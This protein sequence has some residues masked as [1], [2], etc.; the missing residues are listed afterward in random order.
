[1]PESGLPAEVPSCL[2][3]EMVLVALFATQTCEPTCAMPLGVLRLL[4]DTVARAT[5]VPPGAGVLV[6]VAAAWGVLV[7]VGEGMLVAVGVAWGIVVAVGADVLVAV[8]A[9]CGVLVA[10]VPA[11]VIV[12]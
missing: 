7:A 1:M 2:K 8:G 4:P 10:V 9:A 5:G 3:R 12:Y 6:A 11:A